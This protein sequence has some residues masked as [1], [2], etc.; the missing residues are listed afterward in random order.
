MSSIG[1]NTD[2]KMEIIR[3][4]VTKVTNDMCHF[5]YGSLKMSQRIYAGSMCYVLQT[6][7]NKVSGNMYV[8]PASGEVYV[9]RGIAYSSEDCEYE[10]R[11]KPLIPCLLAKSGR[12]E[13]II[14]VYEAKFG[15]VGVHDSFY[16]EA[17]TDSTSHLL[18]IDG[19]S[20]DLGGRILTAWTIP[21]LTAAMPGAKIVMMSSGEVLLHVRI[22]E[23]SMCVDYTKGIREVFAEPLGCIEEVDRE[24]ARLHI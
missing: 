1:R 13:C 12:R 16:Y 6:E 2:M 4:G 19:D 23:S 15:S 14:M 22:D 24:I 11:I 5:A 7:S 10:S 9:E 3:K 8:M 18:T 20:I 17:I 21:F